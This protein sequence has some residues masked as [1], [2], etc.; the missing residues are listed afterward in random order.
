MIRVLKKIGV[1]GQ[2]RKPG[3][4]LEAG[5]DEKT[6]VQMGVAEFCNEGKSRDMEA[7]T[8]APRKRRKKRAV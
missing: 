6:L 2:A 4:V 7:V 3:E 8:V 5:K 1:S